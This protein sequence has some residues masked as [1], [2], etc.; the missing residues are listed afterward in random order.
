MLLPNAVTFVGPFNPAMGVEAAVAQTMLVAGAFTSLSASLDGPAAG[1]SGGYAVTIRR[2]G[3]STGLACGIANTLTSCTVTGLA[4]FA[5][6]DT[7]SLMIEALSG[8]T[9]RP[10]RWTASFVPALP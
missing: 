8:P 2:N 5:V 3:V 9:L 6:G 10:M 1:G 7:M 4:P